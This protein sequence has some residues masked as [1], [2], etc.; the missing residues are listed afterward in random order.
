MVGCKAVRPFIWVLQSS[1]R[2][3]HIYEAPDTLVRVGLD[4]YGAAYADVSSDP[5][6]CQE[7]AS[8]DTRGH[9]PCIRALKAVMCFGKPCPAGE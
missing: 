3:Q 8:A 6:G 1:F 2:K 5:G 7:M 4:F 9:R